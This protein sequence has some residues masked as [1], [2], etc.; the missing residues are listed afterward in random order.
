MG[1]GS[2]GEG[3]GFKGL[4]GLVREGREKKIE[5]T[6]A[7]GMVRLGIKAWKVNGFYHSCALRFRLSGLGFD[8]G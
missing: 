4:G 1:V 3:L 7:F 5:T 8:R 2:R 6:M